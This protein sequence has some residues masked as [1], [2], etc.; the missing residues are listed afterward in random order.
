[1]YVNTHKISPPPAVL[2]ECYQVLI[3]DHQEPLWKMKRWAKTHCQSFV[4]V[5]LIDTT[6]VSY[7]YDSITAFYFGNEQDQLMFMLKY[8]P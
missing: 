2:A 4:W 8:K 3:P 7:T 1:M 6:D 5:E